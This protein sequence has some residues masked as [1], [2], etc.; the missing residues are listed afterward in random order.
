MGGTATPS[1]DGQGEG[2]AT[3][4]KPGGPSRANGAEDRGMKCLHSAALLGLASLSLAQVAPDEILVSGIGGLCHMRQDGS[5][6]VSTTGG[7]GSV[8]TGTGI[9]PDGRWVTTRRDPE[10]INI[11][12]PTTGNEVAT[13][14]LTPNMLSPRGPS[15]FSDGAIAISDEYGI[16]Q[17][18]DVLGNLLVEIDLPGAP[19]FTGGSFVDDRDQL[20]VAH[21][22]YPTGLYRF[23]RAGNMLGFFATDDYSYGFHVAGDGTIWLSYYGEVEHWER[24]GTFLGSFASGFGNVWGITVAPDGTV[25]VTGAYTELRQFAPDGTLLQQVSQNCY[26]YFGNARFGRPAPIGV[27]H[28]QPAAVNSTGVAGEILAFGSG[29]P[30]DELVL[31]AHRLPPGEISFFVGGPTQG[32]VPNAGGQGTLCLSGSIAR[33]ND[34][35]APTIGGLSTWTIDPGDMPLPPTFHYAVTSGET[36]TF[37]CWHRD[38]STSNLTSAVAL[39]FQ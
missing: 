7:T 17:Y 9:L 8:W 35:I 5:V 21:W 24:D 19:T 34:G 11:F 32:F 15:L 33:W 13:F 28:C 39:T 3:L 38:Q 18:Y 37:Q 29:T 20:W 1:K 14:D 6:V 30:G 36:W 12:D 23:D 22:G 31:H 10:G 25:W 26:P 4:W 27:P 16:V 2:V